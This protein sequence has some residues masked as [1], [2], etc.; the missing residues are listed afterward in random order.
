MSLSM[1][2][3]A[4]Q[5]QEVLQELREIKVKWDHK[6]K[7]DTQEDQDHRENTENVVK[8]DHKEFQDVKEIRV[9]K[10]L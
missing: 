3:K 5:A 6:E 2:L 1:D 4:P 10:G 9:L 8:Q 7:L